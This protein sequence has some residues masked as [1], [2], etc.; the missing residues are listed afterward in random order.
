VERKYKVSQIPS[1]NVPV[2]RYMRLSYDLFFC[3]FINEMA[4]C[5]TVFNPTGPIGNTNQRMGV[6]GPLNISEMGSCAM[7]E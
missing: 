5:R 2:G 1:I 3:L 4:K 6:H 7:E